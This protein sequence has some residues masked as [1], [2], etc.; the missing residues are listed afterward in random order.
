[1][2]KFILFLIIFLAAFTQSLAGFGSRL[3][4]MAFLPGLLGAR[5]G[6]T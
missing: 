4:V 3:L 2:L 5:M 1:M 6:C